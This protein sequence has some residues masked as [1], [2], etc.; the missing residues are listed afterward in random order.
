MEELNCILKEIIIKIFMEMQKEMHGDFLRVNHLLHGENTILTVS[1]EM[2]CLDHSWAIPGWVEEVVGIAGWFPGISVDD[3]L[4]LIMDIVDW[5]F[6]D[7]SF[8]VSECMENRHPTQ[9]EAVGKLIIEGESVSL[10]AKIKLSFPDGSLVLSKSGIDD[11]IVVDDTIFVLALV[12]MVILVG[13]SN[14]PIDIG[15][16]LPDVRYF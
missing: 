1:V 9:A 10:K 6:Q 14:Q 5:S 7:L 11:I 13:K 2:V 16:I 8:L 12:L 3:L 15:L 4:T